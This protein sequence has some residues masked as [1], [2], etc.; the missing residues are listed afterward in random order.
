LEWLGTAR[1]ITDRK[2]A[3]VA[4]REGE[5]RQAFLL[6]LS[7]ALRPVA[8]PVAIQE[9]ASRMTAEHLDIG[10][11]AY[12]EIRY[13]PNIMV[14]VERDWPRRGMPPIAAGRYRMDDFGTC[15]AEELTAGRPE[16]VADAS[17]DPRLSTADRKNWTAFEIMASC[18]LPVIKDGLFVAYLAAQDNRP[19]HW[20]DHDIALLSEVSERIWAAIERARAEEALRESE[21]QYR[22][23][24]T[25]RRGLLHHR[26]PLR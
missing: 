15:L 6:K 16:N 18:S 26:G 1:D 4:L 13:E 2:L 19:H 9:I 10:R 20:T 7:D 3:E 22:S 12:C 23:L 14:I 5:E 25:H 17:T 8:D 11:V 24:F 21:A